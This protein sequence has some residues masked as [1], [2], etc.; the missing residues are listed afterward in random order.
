MGAPKELER[1]RTTCF[2]S[3]RDGV[4]A[5]PRKMTIGLRAGCNLAT[6]AAFRRAT[7]DKRR[8]DLDPGNICKFK[9]GCD[10]QHLALA[11]SQ[12]HEGRF[13]PVRDGPDGG[14]HNARLGSHVAEIV[15]VDILS[16]GS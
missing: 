1:K 13:G 5:S 12:I 8:G 6:D 7:F 2:D 4:E 16:A 10:R 11:A 3:P 14:A 9:F 15:C